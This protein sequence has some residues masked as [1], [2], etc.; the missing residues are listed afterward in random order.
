M[1]ALTEEE[2][3]QVPPEEGPVLIA[4]FDGIGGARRALELL[5]ITPAIYVSIERDEDCQ[6]VV[7]DAWPEV[8]SIEDAGSTSNQ[9]K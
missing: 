3:E 1:C 4:A 5:D 8:V 9:I 6:K 7:E 2:T